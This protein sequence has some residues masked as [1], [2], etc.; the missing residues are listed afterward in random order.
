MAQIQEVH[1][2]LGAFGFEFDYSPELV[3]WLD[4]YTTLELWQGEERVWAG[5][6]T[7]LDVHR[8]GIVVA[9]MGLDWHLGLDNDGP[10]ILARSYLSGKSALSNGDWHLDDNLWQFPEGTPWQLHDGKAV[11]AGPVTKN[12]AIVSQETFPMAGGQ[13]WRVWGSIFHPTPLFDEGR[14]RLRLVVKGSYATPNLYP[15]YNQ[16]GFTLRDGET[17]ETGSDIELFPSDPGG[18]LTGDVYEMES[19]RPNLITN[20]SFDNGLTGWVQASGSWGTHAGPDGMVAYTNGDAT[21]DKQLWAD[22]PGP[23]DHFPVKEEEEYAFEGWTHPVPSVGTD[24][25]AVVTIWVGSTPAP[26]PLVPA[27]TTGYY[28]EVLRQ[29]ASD[30]NWRWGQKT[31]TIDPTHTMA[32]PRVQAVFCTAGTWEA[33]NVRFFRTRGN[34]ATRTGPTITVVPG[35]RYRVEV[36]FRV[37]DGVAGGTIT[38]RALVA[39]VRVPFS[40]LSVLTVPTSQTE[41]G[42]VLQRATAD[43]EMPSGCEWL[44]LQWHVQDVFGGVVWVGAPTL[45]D[46]D[47]TTKWFETYSYQS[48]IEIE[49]TVTI[50]EG[51]EEGHLEWVAEVGST[52]WEANQATLTRVDT[53]AYQVS[54]IARAF[55]VHPATNYPLLYAGNIV[56][57]GHLTSDWHIRNLT[58]R[59]A[60]L[61]LCRSGLSPT[62]LETHVRPDGYVDVG[63]AETLFEDRMNVVLTDEDFR[64]LSPL[65][66]V[67]SVKNRITNLLVIGA[68]RQTPDGRRFQISAEATNPSLGNDYMGNPVWRTRVVADSTVDHADYAAGVARYQADSDANPAASV[69]VSLSDWR[70]LGRFD[71]GDRIP[72]YNPTA[73]IEDRDNEMFAPDGSVVWPVMWR[74]LS[75][76]TRLGAGPYRLIIR[77]ARPKTYVAEAYEIPDQ[78]VRW[79]S[80][81]SAE[82]EVGDFRPEFAVDSAQGAATNQFHRF[83]ASA[84]H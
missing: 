24:G 77:R 84:P 22:G 60:L 31:F 23:F 26:G 25:E 13:R 11:I 82:I 12:E 38:L 45:V 34:I 35:R 19:A 56:A 57:P 18:V 5:T 61:H 47:P 2:G 29:Q 48:A 68:E 58:N 41:T 69:R 4:D 33:D 54:D 43:I 71:V 76:T 81:T 15:G 32:M 30:D 16:W 51:T 80:D 49:G 39:G 83:W 3:E 44:A 66:R 63:P 28:I 65:R 79:E 62:P 40:T 74:V 52:G 46:A 20:P 9:G 55:L 72:L 6:V 50:P 59:Q 36:P 14:V 7:D 70:S 75:R 67:R 73:E 10:T 37:G 17:L 42:T 1:M 53:P 27:P 78:L 21:V 64:L 8:D